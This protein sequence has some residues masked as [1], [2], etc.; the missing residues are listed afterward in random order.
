[1]SFTEVQ[2]TVEQWSS[3][4]QDRLAAFLTALRLQRDGAY[5]DEMDRRLQDK[6]PAN[7]MVLKDAKA[8]FKE[9]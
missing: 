5:M 9:R 6:D 4:D 1:M 3:D 7:W 8:K 2:K